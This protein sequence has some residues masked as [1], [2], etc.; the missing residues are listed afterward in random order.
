MPVGWVRL[1]VLTYWGCRTIKMNQSPE[2]SD[3]QPNKV[4]ESQIVNCCPENNIQGNENRAIQGDENL[5]VQGNANTVN[6]NSNNWNGSGS[7]FIKNV[8]ADQISFINVTY[9][10]AISENK[11]NDSQV[12]VENKEETNN[13]G[14]AT[15]ILTGTIDIVDENFLK[16]L[17]THLRKK[18]KD[19]EL[20][21]LKVEEGSIKITLE[22]SQ[23]SLELLKKLFESGELNEVLDI[24]VEDVQ[25]TKMDVQTLLLKSFQKIFENMNLEEIKE[26]VDEKGIDKFISEC[27]LLATTSGFGVFPTMIIGLPADVLNNVTQQFRVTLA[28]IYDKKGIYKISFPQL[29]K[30]VGVSLGVDIGTTL[31]KPIMLS[32]ANRIL[33]RLSVTTAIKA[34]PSIGATIGGNYGFIIGIVAA[35]KRIDMSNISF[36]QDVEFDDLKDN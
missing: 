4:V 22:A 12:S 23:E 19:A 16:L 18:S 36:E 8:Q 2:N 14:K 9:S 5:A 33:T 17:E 34:L 24:P 15:F 31:T 21:I 28:V 6:Q 25:I 1:R 20:T 10:E 29:M 35:V 11:L 26:S 13:K 32:I 7:H 27:A 30:I 3:S